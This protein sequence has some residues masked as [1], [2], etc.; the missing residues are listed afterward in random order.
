MSRARD[1]ADGGLAGV[2]TGSGNVTITDGNLILDAGNG[3]DFSDTTDA[4]GMTSEL[5]DDYEEGTWTPVL[6]PQTGTITTVGTVS[7]TYTKVGNIVKAHC[8]LKITTNGTGATYLKVAGLPFS[9]SESNTD[10]TG[11]G[12]E[13]YNTGKSLAVW[14]QAASTVA[15]RFYD[16]TY[17]GA[18]GNH[19]SLTNIYRT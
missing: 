16:V 5:L 19:F 13:I 17:P 3:I 18:D 2:T 6:T 1:R 4:S 8:V 9:F 7:G 11:Y 14:N 10:D 15:F 12:V